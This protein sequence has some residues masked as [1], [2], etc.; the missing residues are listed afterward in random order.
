MLIKYYKYWEKT[1]EPIP[2]IISR[3]CCG[4]YIYKRFGF[5]YTSPTIGLYMSNDD[6]LLFCLHIGDFLNVELLE[7]ESCSKINYPIGILKTLWG[8][9]LI[10]FLHYKSFDIAK[11]KWNIRKKRVD[12]SNIKII[13]DAKPKICEDFIIRF[14]QIPY[15][16]ILL[17]SCSD[18]KKYPFCYNMK[19][20]D[21]NITP[22]SL[23]KK[24]PMS[25][26]Y[27]YIDEYNWINFLSE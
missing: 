4:G 27:S 14:S 15:K 11:E 9:V 19:C 26:E 7:I 20:Y 16:K 21:M 8:N 17:T 3:D 18:M 5:Q 10:H 2:T 1:L 24:N 12:Y 6:F 22:D 23:I 13:C 25:R